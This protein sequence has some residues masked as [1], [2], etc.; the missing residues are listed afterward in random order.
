[1]KIA[2]LSDLHLYARYLPGNLPK[3]RVLI[4]T[5]L[6][7][8]ADHLV[9]TGD[10]THNAD[11]DDF[12]SLRHLLAEYDLLDARKTTIVIGNHDIFGGVHLAEEI[13]TFPQKCQR[14]DY[15]QKI[16]EFQLGFSELFDHA[17]YLQT[18]QVFPFGKVVDDVLLVGLNSTQ[19][20]SIVKNP[21]ASRGNIIKKQRAGLKAILDHPDFR[22]KIKIILLHHHFNK[23]RS[24]NNYLIDIERFVGRLSHQ[25]RLMK[26]F[27]KHQ[28]S[29]ILHGH[30]H[31]SQ[32]YFRDG[33]RFFNA[34]ASTAENTG[35]LNVISVTPDAIETEIIPVPFKF[36]SRQ[37]TAPA[38]A[39]P[40]FPAINI[41]NQSPIS[42][43]V[44]VS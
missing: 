1:M 26:I 20:Y 4:E 34:G 18:D 29:L 21:F 5:A 8:G 16:R 12:I 38:K 14:V 25:P 19:P 28:V 35:K 10:I 9:I 22:D 3:T 24:E 37:F 27:R 40:A 2:H 15:L 31:R 41:P 36:I 43:P 32:E 23:I 11:F 39:T 42:L 13:L 6:Q 44:I 30:Q 7:K 33:L 17:F